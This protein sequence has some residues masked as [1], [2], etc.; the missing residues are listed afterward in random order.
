MSKARVLVLC[1]G[2]SCRSQM[3]EGYLRH[4]GGEALEVF[5]AGIEAHGLNP[6]AVQVMAEDGVDI[7][8]HTSDTLDKYEGQQFDYVITV[9]DHARE[10][11]PWMQG[12][13][14]TLHRSFPDP[15][16]AEGSDEEVLRQFRTVRDKIKSF[17]QEFINNLLNE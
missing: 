9:C 2:N 16:R 3:A 6:L 14:A 8:T 17:A 12:L 15:A 1:T 7:S 5:S 11:C 10:Q 13:Q 4:F